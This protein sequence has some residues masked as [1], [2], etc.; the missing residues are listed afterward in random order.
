MSVDTN[1][2]FKVIEECPGVPQEILSPETG[3][4][5]IKAYNDTARIL[6]NRFIDNIEG[7]GND[8]PEE[9]LKAGPAR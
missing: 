2:G 4:D 5:S 1:F 7:M 3:W 9:I 6:K 8:I